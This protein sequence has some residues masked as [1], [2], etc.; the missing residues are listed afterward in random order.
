[1]LFS[2]EFLFLS[3]FRQQY[4]ATYDIIFLKLKLM[5]KPILSI[6]LENMEFYLNCMTTFPVSPGVK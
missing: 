4:Q 3:L 1:M 2:A 5:F 6:Q